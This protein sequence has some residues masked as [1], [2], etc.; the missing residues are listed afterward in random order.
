MPRPTVTKQLRQAQ[1]A[2]YAGTLDLGPDK[3]EVLTMREVAALLG[4]TVNSLGVNLWR[5]A[6]PHRRLGGRLLFVR[7]QLREWLAGRIEERVWID[8]FR[9]PNAGAEYWVRETIEPPAQAEI[10]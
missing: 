8:P 3:P 7:E 5:Y 9:H 1:R 4:I 6:V 10:G 2:L